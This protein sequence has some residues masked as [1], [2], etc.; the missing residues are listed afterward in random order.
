M[1]TQNFHPALIAWESTWVSGPPDDPYEDLA[2]ID[3]EELYTLLSMAEDAAINTDFS[4]PVRHQCDAA[5][6]R[7]LYELDRR[8]HDDNE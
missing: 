8:E 5:A 2:E 1:K 4:A 7:I 6:L 3:T